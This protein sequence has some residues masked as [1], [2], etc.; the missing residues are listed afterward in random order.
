M[1]L[2]GSVLFFLEIV[3]MNVI[4]LLIVMLPN[5][6]WVQSNHA[7]KIM[8]RAKSNYAPPPQKQGV[9]AHWPQLIHSFKARPV[10]KLTDYTHQRLVSGSM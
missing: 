5:N 1:V 6:D 10:A 8:T 4:K 9:K 3:N 2:R 7:A